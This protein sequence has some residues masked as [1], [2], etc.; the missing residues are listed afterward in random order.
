MKARRHGAGF[1]LIEVL[2]VLGIFAIIGLIGARIVERVLA[3]NETLSERGSRLLEVQRAMQILQRDVLQLS[4]RGVRD[5]LGDPVEPL[6]IGADGMIEFTRFG[7]R[8][9]LGRPRSELQRVG[10]VLQDGVLFRAYWMVLDRAPDS[11]PELQRLLE[12]VEQIE[13]SAL[14]VSGN[15]YSFWPPAGDFRNDP[16]LQLAAI[17]LRLDTAPFGVIERVWPVPNPDAQLNAGLPI[18]PGG[19]EGSPESGGG[20]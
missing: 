11:E 2:I 4:G 10:Y 15:E 3:N 5:G 19:G 18:G 1:T 16:A 17:V 6:L 12:D 9:P 14:D 8:N 13:F 7:W 20:E